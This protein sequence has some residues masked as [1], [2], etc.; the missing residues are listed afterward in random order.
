[1]LHYS[2]C[3]AS[4]LH[5]YVQVYPMTFQLCPQLFKHTWQFIDFCV[6]ILC[7]SWVT[8]QLIQCIFTP[9]AIPVNSVSTLY[10]IV[11]ILGNLSHLCPIW[12]DWL[13]VTQGRARWFKATAWPQT[14]Q[15]FRIGP[16]FC[17]ISPDS[18][19]WMLASEATWKVVKLLHDW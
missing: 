1:M 10:F 2:I 18:R 3:W 11:N 12:H 15:G 14:E 4:P 16:G 5:L 13:Q 19:I 17:W 8:L 6:L 7:K 9:W